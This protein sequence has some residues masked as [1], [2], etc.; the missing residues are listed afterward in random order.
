MG[1]PVILFTSGY[2]G[3]FIHFHV[4]NQTLALYRCQ[5]IE[6][7]VNFDW[8]SENIPFLKL[9]VSHPGERCLVVYNERDD[10]RVPYSDSLLIFGG[11]YVKH[12][13]SETGKVLWGYNVNANDFTRNSQFFNLSRNLMIIQS[14]IIQYNIH[15][16]EFDHQPLDLDVIFKKNINIRHASSSGSNLVVL[17]DNSI[18]LFNSEIVSLRELCIRTIVRNLSLFY[19]QLYYFSASPSI[20]SSFVRELK[21]QQL[22][23]PNM[24]SLF[25]KPQ[26]R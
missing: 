4:N 3:K 12:I 23:S 14:T 9:A 11:S 7:L 5:R 15:T 26:A 17:F 1:N 24:S 13:D 16:G 20:V 19:N 8:A 2:H 21:Y 18:H 22:W 10:T 6:E 25:S